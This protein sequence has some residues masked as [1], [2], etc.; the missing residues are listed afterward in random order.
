MLVYDFKVCTIVLRNI[1]ILGWT[2]VESEKG[3]IT[4]LKKNIKKISEWMK[5]MMMIIQ[6]LINTLRC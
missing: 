6:S 2:E 3:A 4:H 1:L 5:M